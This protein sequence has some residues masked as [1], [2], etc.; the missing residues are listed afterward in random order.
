LKIVVVLQCNQTTITFK[1]NEMTFQE[2][3]FSVI[4]S[5]EVFTTQYYEFNNKLVRVGNHLPNP[6]NFKTHNSECDDILLVFVSCQE[7][8][9]EMERCVEECEDYLECNVTCIIVEEDECND[10]NKKLIERF[11]NS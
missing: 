1:T 10:I 7:G 4:D 6:R 3:I 8:E 2:Q 9:Y 11:L 5:K